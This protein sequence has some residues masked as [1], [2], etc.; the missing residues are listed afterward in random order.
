MDIRQFDCLVHELAFVVI[1]SNVFVYVL[2]LIK[3]RRA[4][5]VT[6]WVTAVVTSSAFP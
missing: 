2:K 3:Q 5:S 6:G 4:W 1:F